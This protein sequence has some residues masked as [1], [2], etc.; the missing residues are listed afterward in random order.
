MANFLRV[1]IKFVQIHRKRS[2][3]LFLLIHFPVNLTNPRMSHNLFTS[4]I[5]SQSL[6][7]IFTREPPDQ[8]FGLLAYHLRREVDIIVHYLILG[9]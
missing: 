3:K 5:V 7:L 1:K 4:P 6:P 2:P 9:L 8:I